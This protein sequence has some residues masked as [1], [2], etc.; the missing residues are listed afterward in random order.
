MSLGRASP[1]PTRWGGLDVHPLQEKRFQDAVL[2]ATR[3]YN[4]GVDMPTKAAV[5]V[6]FL[7]PEGVTGQ[8]IVGAPPFGGSAAVA[9]RGPR[10]MARLEPGKTKTL[11]V[12][13]RSWF[14]YLSPLEAARGRAQWVRQDDLQEL[15]EL[16]EAWLQRF[17]NVSYVEVDDP[18]VEQR[19][20]LSQYVIASLSRDLDFPSNIFG[21][22]SWDRPIWC[23]DHKIDYNYEIS[24][25][26][27]YSSG[28][29]DQAAPYEAPLLAAMDNVQEMARRLPLGRRGGLESVPSR[30]P[31]VK[32]GHRGVYFAIGLGPKGH[33]PENGSWGAKNQNAFAMMPIAWRWNLTRDLDYAWKVY[34]LVR[35]VASF[36]EDEL[37]FSNGFYVMKG[38]CPGE[39]GGTE[40][41]L[42]SLNAANALSFLRATMRL[43][44]ELSDALGV[45]CSRREKWRHILEH[46]NPYPTKLADQ[47]QIDGRPL[48]DVFPAGTRTGRE[49]FLEQE[50]ANTLGRQWIV[51]PAGEL[52]PDSDPKLLKIARDTAEAEILLNIAYP[53]SDFQNPWRHFNLD[54]IFFPA[55]VRIG[56]NSE[57]IWREMHSSILDIGAPN[58]F[59]T[60]NPHGLE[61]ANTVPNTVNEM[62][63]LSHENVLRFHRVWPRKSHPNARFQNLRAYGVFK[64]SAALVNGE[65]AYV[66]IV[67]EK[68]PDCTVE[69]PWPGK[70]VTVFR[71]SRKAETVQGE[72]FA[73]KTRPGELIELRA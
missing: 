23:G 55:T 18:V 62:M 45:D 20:F 70:R 53:N 43:V 14:K 12:A 71:G 40:A 59:R 5:A 24:F 22:E 36:W 9:D 72:K 11:T 35:E 13:M 51:Y 8:S 50:G 3:A 49:V 37:A 10:L 52:G 61:K 21:F 66:R 42:N 1:S 48:S 7:D 19:Y 28:H 32:N 58:G 69:N 56:Y 44:L 60:E 30:D 4:E 39:C 64:V 73:L 68:G 63:L 38:D 17:W 46:M 27:M 54:C 65:V 26:A 15:R 25:A 41:A 16:H 47:I 6:Q 31:A 2:W 33:L 29:F 34:P 67:S 57:V